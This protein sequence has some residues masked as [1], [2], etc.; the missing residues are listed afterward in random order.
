G[1][2]EAFEGGGARAHWI[3]AFNAFRAICT[4]CTQGRGFQV[5]RQSQAQAADVP[6]ESQGE[7]QVASGKARDPAQRGEQIEQVH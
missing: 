4:F 5:G 6:C 3:N 1:G 2:G 7:Q